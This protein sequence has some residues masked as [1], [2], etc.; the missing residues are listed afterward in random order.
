[1]PP[2]RVNHASSF[3][4]V[5]TGSLGKAECKMSGNLVLGGLGRVDDTFRQ[6][7]SIT[8]VQGC[9]PADQRVN[10]VVVKGGALV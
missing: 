2:R 1:M 10:L 7:Q 4:I 8:R 9:F 6:I 5:M 3:F